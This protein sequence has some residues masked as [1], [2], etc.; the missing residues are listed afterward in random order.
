[1]EHAVIVMVRWMA[2]GIKF[3][4]LILQFAFFNSQAE[5]AG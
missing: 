3:S 2:C 1:M 4:I 5:G